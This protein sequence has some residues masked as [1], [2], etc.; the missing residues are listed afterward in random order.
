MAAWAAV[1]AILLVTGA[2]IW[3]IE[4]RP[5]V[6]LHDGPGDLLLTATGEI[7]G[8]PGMSTLDRVLV[9]AAMHRG[10]LPDPPESWDSPRGADS[11]FRALS[12]VNARVLE[13]RPRFQWTESP[14]AKSYRVAIY[15]EGGGVVVESDPL[16]GTEW[17]APLALP[18]M[19]KL[20]WH[21]TA[22]RGAERLPAPPAYFEIISTES[23]GRIRD[24]QSQ[25]AP[26]RLLLAVLFAREGM[27]QDAARELAALAARNPG[28]PLVKQLQRSLTAQ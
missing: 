18:R 6:S 13:E 17:I 7:E 15:A 4:L 28:S 24:A 5:R 16:A 9:A 21:V 12:P 3:R 2:V 1:A 23:A 8:V 25:A 10:E 19:K 22:I 11:G 27:R 14:G 26:S 20:S